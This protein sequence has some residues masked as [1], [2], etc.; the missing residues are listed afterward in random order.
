M[1]PSRL[2]ACGDFPAHA[3]RTAH[4]CVQHFLQNSPGPLGT[5]VPSP[6]HSAHVTE[7]F[8]PP[9]MLV[10][11]VPLQRVDVL[12]SPGKTRPRSFFIFLCASGTMPAEYV[13]KSPQHAVEGTHHGRR[14]TVCV[15]RA[16]P[17]ASLSA[18]LVW[19]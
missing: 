19:H 7:K 6:P 12:S 17:F 1:A 4:H 14:E 2:P 15:V 8:L 13:L 3:L 16:H 5:N 11:S 18:V 9:R 10:P